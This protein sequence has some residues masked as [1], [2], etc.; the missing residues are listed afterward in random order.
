LLYT[1]PTYQQ[2]LERDLLNMPAVREL[3]ARGAGLPSP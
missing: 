1:L 3:R 2:C